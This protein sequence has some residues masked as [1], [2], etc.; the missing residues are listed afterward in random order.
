[1]KKIEYLYKIY[2]T[3]KKTISFFYIKE[4]KKNGLYTQKSNTK[5]EN[6]IMLRGRNIDTINFSH[7]IIL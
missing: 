4:R 5:K 7:T 1:M 3:F 6:N 2:S